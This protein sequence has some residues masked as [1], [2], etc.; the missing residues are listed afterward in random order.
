MWLNVCLALPYCIHVPVN[1]LVLTSSFKRFLSL[2]AKKRSDLFFTENVFEKTKNLNQHV[3]R[4]CYF[5]PK[6]TFQG[7]GQPIIAKLWFGIRNAILLV[8]ATILPKSSVPI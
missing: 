7:A 4:L 6:F 3:F 5:L 1:N 8:A 2:S